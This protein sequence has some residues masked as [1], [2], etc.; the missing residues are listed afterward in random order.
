MYPVL[1]ELGVINVY[2]YGLLVAAA[3]LIA[4]QVAVVRGR[5]RQVAAICR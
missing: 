1:L 2:T 4:L 3:Y 5:R